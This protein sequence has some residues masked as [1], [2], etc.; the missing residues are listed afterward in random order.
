MELQSRVVSE[1]RGELGMLGQ[2]AAVINAERLHL[3]FKTVNYYFD[4]I[5]VKI[6]SLIHNSVCS[7]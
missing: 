2:D 6:K 3:T 1:L 4:K 5:T 7:L